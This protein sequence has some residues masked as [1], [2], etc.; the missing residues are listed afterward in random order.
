MSD[1]AYPYASNP[2]SAQDP[3]SQQSPYGQAA[4]AP[5]GQP[6]AAYG[7][8]EAA[9][10][11]PNGT[12]YGQPSPVYAQPYYATSNLVAYADLRSQAQIVMVLAGVS[13]LTLY[14]L[15]SI[16]AMVWSFTLCTKAKDL[17]APPEIVSLTNTARI[18]T[19]ICA[20]IQT[21]VPLAL[22]VAYFLSAR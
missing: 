15:L 21:L 9:Y 20:A 1:P 17:H 3:Y 5:Y 10:G 12:V 14:V 18:V 2:V 8:P 6:E 19:S 7:Q 13:F 11:V 16:P 22:L 4:S